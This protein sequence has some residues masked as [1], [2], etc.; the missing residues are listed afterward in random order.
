[1]ANDASL[2]NQLMKTLKLYNNASLTAG[3]HGLKCVI[4]VASR[5]RYDYG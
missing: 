4:P 2:Q 3:V 5:W 1:M